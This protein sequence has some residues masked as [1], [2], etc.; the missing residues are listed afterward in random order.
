TDF[1]TDLS[2]V[3]TSRTWHIDSNFKAGSPG[4]SYY[5]RIL[6]FRTGS[7]AVRYSAKFEANLAAGVP[8]GLRVVGTAPNGAT[9]AWNHSA[10]ARQYAVRAATDPGFTQGLKTFITTDGRNSLSLNTLA[11][12][13]KYYFQVRALD[14]NKQHIARS[15]YSAA[16]SATTRAAGTPLTVLSSNVLT[17]NLNDGI[18]SHNWTARKPA[19]DDVIGDSAADV[20]GVQEAYATVSYPGVVDAKPQWE[21]LRQGLTARGYQ[22]ALSGTDGL[23]GTQCGSPGCAQDEYLMD[24]NHI[25]YR[26][27]TVRPVG[28]GGKMS[29]FNP[30]NRTSGYTAAWQVFEKLDGS[31]VRFLAVNTHFYWQGI[32]VRGTFEAARTRQAQS[33]V[34]ALRAVNGGGLPVVI[35]GDF[36]SR[37]YHDPVTVMEAAGYSDAAGVDVPQTK[38]GYNSFHG[39]R[40]PP[41]STWG[42]H[43]DYVFVPADVS[44]ARWELVADIDPETGRFAGP[45]PSDHH[46]IRAVLTLP[47]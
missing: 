42:N 40:T 18:A 9:L 14:G 31:G 23:Y 30:D 19:V 10:N 4:R 15:S 7:S 17:A 8:A 16:V 43:I 26:T 46:A 41:P 25:F 28:S 36:N 11:A 39:Y 12:G 3:A 6:A 2:K 37:P 20:V 35:L 47:R 22:R 5:Y 44:A 32:T 45:V 24:G 21:D 34:A 38:A 33:L 27:S 13:R 1:S 29:L